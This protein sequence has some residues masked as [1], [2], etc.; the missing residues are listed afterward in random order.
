MIL[1]NSVIAILM[2]DDNAEKRLDAKMIDNTYFQAMMSKHDVSLINCPSRRYLL[3]T[4]IIKTG[5]T[6]SMI[7]KRVRRLS[8]KSLEF[9]EVFFILF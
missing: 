1:S 8:K 2:T 9:H 4:D 6:C 7:F 5:Y 3:L